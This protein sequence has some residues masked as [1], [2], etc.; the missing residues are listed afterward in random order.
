[1][2]PGPAASGVCEGLAGGLALDL[3]CPPDLAVMGGLILALAVLGPL[4]VALF[5]RWIRPAPARQSDERLTEDRIARL[6]ARMSE[7]RTPVPAAGG[8]APIRPPVRL[9]EAFG[10]SAANMP[11]PPV[12]RT[13]GTATDCRWRYQGWRPGTRIA[14]WACGT[15]GAEASSLHERHPPVDC[16]ADLRS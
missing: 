6:K 3:P 12:L 2:E 8:P 11:S 1:M 13:G 14:R 9:A 5:V 7:P 10:A 16:L 15:C 4:T